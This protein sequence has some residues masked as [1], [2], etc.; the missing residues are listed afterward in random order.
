MAV[1]VQWVLGGREWG[2]G[3][4]WMFLE[5]WSGEH[6]LLEN[7]RGTGL[8]RGRGWVTRPQKVLPKEIILFRVCKALSMENLM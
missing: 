4:L 7:K 8:T 2:C 6:S 5:P 1:T 3:G